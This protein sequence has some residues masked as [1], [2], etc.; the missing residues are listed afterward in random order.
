MKKR[1]IF[2]AIFILIILITIISFKYF[3]NKNVSKLKVKDGMLKNSIGKTIQLR[4]VSSH[5]IQWDLDENIVNYDNLKTLKEEWKINVFR[6]AMY[7]EED[8]Y[9][10]NKEKVKEKVIETIDNC[11]KLKLYV[12]I[13]WHIL[14]DNNPNI[15]KQ[16]AIEFFDDISKIYGK[17]NN[18]IYEICNEPNGDD[19]RWKSSVYPYAKDVIEVIRKNSP[20]SIIIVGTPDWCKSIL[21][22]IGNQLPYK[23]IMYAFHFYSGTHGE[24][25]RKSLEY[26]IENGVP[27]FVSEWGT[28]TAENGTSIFEEESDKWVE[29]LNNKGISWVNWSF[30]NKDE[31]TS[32]LKKET[33]TLNDE[34]LTESGLYVKKKI[35][36]KL[37]T[38]NK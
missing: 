30:S 7:T 11:I 24:L 22:V 12:I 38:T 29:F 20:D 27:V 21:E 13:D 26:A 19:V 10:Y 36:E 2:S 35:Q 9:L 6:I 16:E 5:G 37:L 33:K 18:V 14:S 23:N 25:Y 15:H 32:I 28:S 31:A 34:N 1:T 4:G 8:G 17:N 3:N